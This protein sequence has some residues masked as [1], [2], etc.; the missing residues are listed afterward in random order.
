MSVDQI[1]KNIKMLVNSA[2]HT[3][4]M[5]ENLLNW[6]RTTTGNIVFNVVEHGIENIVLGTFDEVRSQA[7]TK[8]I[9]LIFENKTTE[10]YIYCDA[11]MVNAVLRN[12]ISNAIKFSEKEKTITV[13]VDK[14]WEDDNF[15]LIS[16]L[17]EGVGMPAETVEK[18][19]RLDTKV[20]TKGTSGEPGTGLG[21]I[22]C[23]EFID[24]HNCKIWV[25]SEKDK[26]TTF[27]F[28]LPKSKTY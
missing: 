7:H 9:E 22:L 25:E 26:G 15:I 6:A 10:K 21:L 28:T 16:V 11:N 17:D 14:C 20:S 13:I 12:L 1:M 8:N 5:L 24:K 3:G 23:K 18:L 19:F 4:K 27:F 2:T